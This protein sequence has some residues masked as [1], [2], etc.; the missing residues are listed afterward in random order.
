[1]AR[2]CSLCSSPDRE[3]VDQ[4]IRDKVP[5]RDIAGRYGT[6][7]SAVQ[8]HAAHVLQADALVSPPI[9]LQAHGDRSYLSDLESLHQAALR[10]FAV[11]EREQNS[12]A[13][14]AWFRELRQTVETG[15]KMSMLQ[16]QANRDVAPAPTIGD[17]PMWPRV[18]NT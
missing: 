14:C 1:M 3:E 17:H 18:R 4:A 15:F 16:K 9:P 6:S 5:I 13:A 12:P 2:T 11:A 8:R 7:R 10:W